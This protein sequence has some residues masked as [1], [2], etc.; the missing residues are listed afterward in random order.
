MIQR[1]QYM[2]RMKAFRDNKLIKVVN[3]R[4]FWAVTPRLPD[5]YWQAASRRQWSV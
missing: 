3:R 5:V 2:E 4:I 1:K